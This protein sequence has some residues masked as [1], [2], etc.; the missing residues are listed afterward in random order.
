MKPFR[1][2]IIAGLA[3]ILAAPLFAPPASAQTPSAVEKLNAYVGCINR[4]SARAYD[5]RARYFSWA[6]KSGPT[7]R[8][9]IIY[10]TYTIYDTADCRKDVE[11]ANAL[12]PHDAELEA[13][14]SAYAKAASKLEP[15]LKEADDYYKQEELQGR[16]D[17]QGQGPASPARR[18]LGRLRERRPEA[19]R[20]RRR[21]QRQTRAGK[22]SPP[23]RK[24]KARQARYH[25]EALMI[26]AK[27][28]L[29]AEESGKPE[30]AE[31]TAALADYE[32]IVKA[33]EQFAGLRRRARSARFS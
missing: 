28:L 20:R 3:I 10:G 21:H 15:L 18:R 32:S 7:G 33:A 31:I 1:A 27:R 6:A 2:S 4:L 17:G 9:H 5:S 13:A 30:L 16:Q 24:A 19:A 8:E 25:V 23:S 12:E 26:Q 11:K 22:N 14:A 29:R